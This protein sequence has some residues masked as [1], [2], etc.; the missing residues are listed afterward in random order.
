MNKINNCLWIIDNISPAD[1]TSAQL[2]D[3]TCKR[4]N[5][6]PSTIILRSLHT[7]K[8]NLG[9]YGLGPR[10]CAPLA[11]GLVVSFPSEIIR[12]S[13]VSSMNI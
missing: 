11:V 3:E 7:T 10:G 1:K 5:I 9:N 2:Y 4:L 12:I 6:C 13:I 8:I